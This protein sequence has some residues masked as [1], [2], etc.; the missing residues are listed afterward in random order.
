MS[1]SFTDSSQ[2]SFSSNFIGTFGASTNGGVLS[3]NFTNEG[4]NPVKI[5][6]NIVGFGA[7]S[8]GTGHID[9]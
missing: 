6:S 4:S 7:T 2:G 5:R 9:S 8:S 1:Q 3:L